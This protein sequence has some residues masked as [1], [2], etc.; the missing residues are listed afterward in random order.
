[1]A[2][3]AGPVALAGPLGAA[4]ALATL[5]LVDSEAILLLLGEETEKGRRMSPLFLLYHWC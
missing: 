2:N 5:P 4:A 1:M 3:P